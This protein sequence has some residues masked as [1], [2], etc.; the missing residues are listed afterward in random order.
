MASISVF[1]DTNVLI[2]WLVKEVD[3]KTGGELWEAPYQILKQIETGEVMGS[4]S[5]I[6]LMEVIFVPRRK[7]K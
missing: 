2:S 1:L 5:I 7:K 6:N 3:P 4:T